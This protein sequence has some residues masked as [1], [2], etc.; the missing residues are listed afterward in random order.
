MRSLY[1]MPQAGRD[2]FRSLNRFHRL[3]FLPLT[4]GLTAGTYLTGEMVPLIETF[5]SFTDVS[6]DILLRIPVSRYLSRL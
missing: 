1:T 3:A 5:T 6:L 2:T 4:K